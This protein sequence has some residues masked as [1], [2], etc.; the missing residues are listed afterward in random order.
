MK[1]NTIMK[2]VSFL[3]LLFLPAAL[4][5]SQSQDA[6]K[7]LQSTSEGVIS[8]IALGA[9][10]EVMA[11]GSAFAVEP[12]V[13]ATAYQLISKAREVEGISSKGK[14]IKIEGILSVD[15]KLNLALL[16]TKGKL[17]TL[18]LGNSDEVKEGK[19]LFAVGFNENNEIAVEEGTVKNAL[20]LT[21]GQKVF[22]T[23]LTPHQNFSGGPLVDESGKVM[24]MLI[25]LERRI[26]FMLPSN[27]LKTVQKKSLMKFKDWQ[28]EDYLETLEGAS[29]AGRISA[30]LD[31]TGRAQLYLE[32]VVQ[33]N[34]DDIGIQALLASVYNRQ[35]NYE[36]SIA[37]YQKVIELDRNRDDAYYGLGTVYLRMR[38]FNEAIPPLEKAVQL[39]LDHKEAYFHIGSAY[40]EM[41]DFARAAEAYER[42]L[43]FD[44]QNKGE[45][46]LRLGMCRMNLEQF[47][48]AITAFQEAI[49]D[50]PQDIK[51]NYQLALA[52]QKTN[53][54][55]KAEEVYRMLAQQSPEE[56][57]IY[58]RT[59][60]TM[61]DRAGNSEKA[62]EAAKK[63]IEINPNSEADHYNLG[64]MYM[65]LNRYKDA[66]AAFQEALKI[67]PGYEYAYMNIGYIHYLQ[68]RYADA[69]DVY[70][71]AVSFI[72]ENADAWFYIGVCYMQLKNFSAA[73]EPLS[74]S[75]EL[76]PNNTNALYNLAITYLNLHDKY[77]A[78]EVHKKLKALDPNLAAKLAEYLR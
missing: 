15:K 46:Y 60:L 22:E 5:F 1:R 68:K 6:Q 74:K 69:I 75:V 11:E 42:Y 13:L 67:N 12:G 73:L 36:K 23:S 19:K 10:K 38:R 4:L 20:N 56:A 52:Y 49:K 59:I 58:Y 26:S 35:R 51:I 41:K 43:N 72:P 45:T 77:S 50:N 24:G 63:L 25:F 47:S 27:D 28:P 55:D 18:S 39:N 14:K 48:Q 3:F 7:I 32:K 64:L 61:Y 29:L 33:A 16:S 70:K 65:K 2:S 37:S 57:H 31:E 44:H 9:N 62:I 34:P 66:V 78:R 40:E 30:L 54:L 8:L 17:T 76:R 53:Q 71:K 21:A